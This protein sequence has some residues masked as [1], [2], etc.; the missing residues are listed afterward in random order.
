MSLV[1]VSRERAARE[2]DRRAYGFVRE[3]GS[4]AGELSCSELDRAARRVAAILQAAG[5]RGG[6]RALLVLPPGLDYVEAFFGCL[7]AGVIAVPTYPP[8]GRSTEIVAK[9]AG[10]C[11]P[12]FL[13]TTDDLADLAESAA[14]GRTRPLAVTTSAFSRKE[15]QE[16]AWR[17]P[18]ITADTLAFLQYTSGS[19]GSPKGVMVTHGNLVANIAAIARSYRSSPAD[20]FFSWLPLYHD[21]G[22]IG[23]ILHPLLVG[24]PSLLA[25]PVGF[26]QNPI[27]WLRAIHRYRCTMSGGPNFAYQ[28]CLDQIKDEDLAGI[29]LSCWRIAF[30]GAEPVAPS[31]LRLFSERFSAHGFDP[32]VLSPSYGL[33]ESTLFV[34]CSGCG[35]P[36]PIETFDRPALE[37]DQARAVSADSLTQSG[38][39]SLVGYR[40]DVPEQRLEIV[41]PTNFQA[42]PPGRVGEIW[43]AG[44]SIA[45][46]YWSKPAE[47]AA[48]FQ[49]TLAGDPHGDRFLRTGDLGFTSDGK[50][51]VTGRRKDIL[52]VRGRNYYPQ[53]VEAVATAAHPGLRSGGCAAFTLEEGTEVKL[54]LVAEVKR[55]LVRRLDSAEICGSVRQAV[56]ERLGLQV[57]DIALVL[58]SALPKTSS[59]KVRRS[60]CRR[61]WSAGAFQR[62]NPPESSTPTPEQ[63]AT[64]TERQLAACWSRVLGTTTVGPETSLFQLGADSI[65]VV[66]IAQAIGE[67][68]G[69]DISLEAIYERPSL[70]EMASLIESG[71]PFVSGVQLSEE[72]LLPNDVVVSERSH[73]VESSRCVL[74]TGSTGLLGAYLI[75]EL[76]EATDAHVVCLARASSPEQALARVHQNLAHYD[77]APK[78]LE[79][80]TAVAGDISRPRFGLDP[81]PYAALANRIDAIY[82]SAAQVDWAVPY[83]KLRPANVDGTLEVI[84]FACQGVTKPLHYVST[85]WVFPLGKGGDPEH[86][87]DMETHFPR[88]EG[89]ETGY[90]RSK[91]ASERL[92][93]QARARG[94]PTTIHRMDF[95]TAAATGKFKLTDLVPRLVCDAINLGILPRED[96]RLDLIP[97]DYLSRMIVALSRSPQATG[98]VFH[99][100]NHERLSLAR[101]AGVL[102]DCGYDVQRI[103]YDQW[104]AKIAANKKSALYPLALFLDSYDGEDVEL[105]IKQGADNRQAVDHLEAL[106]PGITTA[107]PSMDVVVRQLLA[108]LTAVRL[109]RPGAGEQQ[110]DRA[111]AG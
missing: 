50:L 54:V 35:S 58:P 38:D 16:D 87:I 60:E 53:D 52:I 78:Q 83:Q 34:A 36:A 103:A 97:V 102:R 108:Q 89:L 41:D 61:R 40:A 24:F 70:R 23:S 28:L 57:R 25:S 93:W 8:R 77:L 7:Y 110:G 92:V 48:T 86:P 47:T 9:I 29:D 72:G 74:V 79:R 21:M 51:F 12:A 30:N 73:P 109:I 80:L 90:N 75:Q 62:L 55:T 96:F 43:L 76:L 69:Y 65:K 91:W 49:A 66:E 94:L 13:M 32:N 10:D 2:P 14:V 1:D 84:R 22:L 82:H 68:L 71:R 104:K 3:D 15:G 39:L 107:M 63:F 98:R 85:M 95:I 26:I 11:D 46:G 56:G 19:T 20:Q 45:K 81:S 99:L 5:A 59:G 111:K 67:S 18:A 44:K 33:A 100:L 106:H 37:R 6:E 27:S 105:S 17:S 42:L 4:L 88:C 101:L 31:T 64:E